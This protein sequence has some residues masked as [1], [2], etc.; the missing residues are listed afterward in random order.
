VILAFSEAPIRG[1]DD[2]QARLTDRE[3]G[4]RSTVKILRGV[5]RLDLDVVPRESK[6]S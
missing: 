1:I 5:E 6:T 4:V 3:V 2:L